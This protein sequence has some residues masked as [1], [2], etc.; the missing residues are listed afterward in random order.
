[1]SETVSEE[2]PKKVFSE[3]ADAEIGKTAKLSA[4]KKGLKARLWK[5]VYENGKEVSRDIFNNSVYKASSAKI[6]V[7]TKSSKPEYT[8]MIRTAIKS[9][10]EEKINKAIA[11]VKAKEAEEAAKKAEEEAKKAEEE[12]KKAAE[13]AKKQEESSGEAAPPQ[14]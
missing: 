7:G 11:D 6:A 9:Q 5:V 12:A 10:N 4:G 14:Q 1:M 2:E 3:D 13:E 8:G